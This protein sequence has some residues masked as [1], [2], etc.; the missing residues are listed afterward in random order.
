MLGFGLEL[1]RPVHVVGSLTL[2]LALTLTLTHPV[3]KL[4]RKCL[5]S[6]SAGVR[7][8]GRGARGLSGG[9]VRAEAREGS[10]DRT[11]DAVEAAENT[12][13]ARLRQRRQKML[14]DFVHVEWQTYVLI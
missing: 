13:T 9:A 10:L 11:D 6:E 12:R 2:S 5:V 1:L 14:T 7:G 8:A 3:H 4:L